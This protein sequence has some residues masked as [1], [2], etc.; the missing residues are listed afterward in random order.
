L[1]ALPLAVR[2][3]RGGLEWA[4]L[5]LGGG[6]GVWVGVS[7]GV[8]G[9]GGVLDL[10]GLVGGARVLGPAPGVGLL[11]RWP[12]VCVMP[13]WERSSS[14]AWSTGRMIRTWSLSGTS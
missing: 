9:R 13:P 12:G 7:V 3:W 5:F 4:G 10:R 11:V 1:L 14:N 8:G 2:V 6:V